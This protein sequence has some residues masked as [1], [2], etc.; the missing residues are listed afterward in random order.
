MN[1][2]LTILVIEHDTQRLP[3]TLDMLRRAGYATRHA[4][5]A[6]AGLALARSACPAALLLCDA[7]TDMP[8]P[9]LCRTVRADALLCEM[10]IV[11]LCPPN[12]SENAL[13]DIEPHVDAILLRS[14]PEY[15]VSAQLKALMRANMAQAAAMRANQERLLLAIDAVNEGI[16]DLNYEHGAPQLFWNAQYY[17]ILGYEPDEFPPAIET[18]KAL[19]HPDDLPAAYQK[20]VNCV[21]HLS[22]DYEHEARLLTNTREWKWIA[23]KGR[24]VKRDKEGRMLRMVGTHSDITARKQA[25]DALRKSEERFRLFMRNFPGIAYIKDADTCVIFANQGFLT[26]LGLNPSEMLGKT[27]R[28]LF[29]PDFA[30]K[31]TAD[32]RRVVDSGQNGMLEETFGGRVWRTYKFAI[33]QQNDPPLLGGFTLDITNQKEAERLLADSEKKFAAA[34]RLNPEPMAITVISTGEILDINRAYEQW[35]G[36]SRNELIGQTSLEAHLWVEASDRQRVISQLNADLS[37]EGLPVKVRLKNGDIRDVLFSA[38]IVPLEDQ[39]ILLTVAHD[40]TPIRQTE[41]ALRKSEQR[42]SFALEGTSDALWDWDVQTGT[43]Y[44]SPRYYT[45]LGYEPDEFPSDYDHW[46]DHL[47]PDDLRPTEEALVAHFAG[48]APGYA[49]E[50]RMKTKQGG[51]RWILGRGKAMER[52]AAGRAI[53]MTGTHTDITERKEAEAEIRRLNAELE[54]RVRQRTAALEAANKE[55]QAFAYVVSHDLKTPLRGISQIAYW[56]ASDYAQAF[57]AEGQQLLSMMIARVKRMD[58]LID[59]ILAYSR[60]GRAEGANEPVNLHDAL[61]EAR[62]LLAPPDGIMISVDTDFPTVIGDAVRLTQVFQN[63]LSNAIKFMDKPDGRIRVGCLSD[64]EVWRCYVADN[65]PGI[66]PKYHDRI[67]RIFQTLAPRDDHESTGIG[68]AVAQ[69]IIE[70]YG[71]RIWVESE[72]GQ[73]ST[74]F[75]TLPKIPDRA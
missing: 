30:A 69:K 36:Y 8:I 19:L 3:E 32:D 1:H 35:S 42:L 27:N 55:L 59:G 43:T 10:F 20:F 50:F 74:F 22:N 7:P 13:N 75:F 6:E 53:R 9:E 46:R 31:I 16:W 48:D 44:F 38:A 49:I 29:P 28:D 58:S 71:G 52:D 18:W 63:L 70:F 67:F 34:F 61:K 2:Q 60:I 15:I 14:A 68:L 62:E 64:G 11:F 24:V 65:G 39:Q 72:P 12:I 45:M 40:I 41:Q 5:T 37:V 17:T 57:D 21:E 51:W 66:D 47:H 23:M 26:Y 4:F 56:L 54:E 25:E 73:G 33:P